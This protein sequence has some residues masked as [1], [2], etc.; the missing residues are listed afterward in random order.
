M[1]LDGL[2][3][4]SR[5][6]SIVVVGEFG[7]FVNHDCS[8][9]FVSVCIYHNNTIHRSKFISRAKFVIEKSC[10]ERIFPHLQPPDSV[11]V[12]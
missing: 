4:D 6:K 8:N 3:T 9:V 2:G 5:F 10:G 1:E 7:L 11:N 12:K